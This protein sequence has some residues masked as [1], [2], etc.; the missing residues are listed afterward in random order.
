MDLDLDLDLDIPPD[1]GSKRR[2]VEQLNRDRPVGDGH[3]TARE[4]RSLRASAG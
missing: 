3:V 2:F 1:P 4:R